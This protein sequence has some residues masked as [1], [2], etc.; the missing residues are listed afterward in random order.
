MNSA[1]VRARAW[2]EIQ[3]FCGLTGEF[4]SPV[5]NPGIG[6]DINSPTAHML[7]EGSDCVRVRSAPK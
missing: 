2:S 6:A 4:A 7:S 3:T 1:L 5:S